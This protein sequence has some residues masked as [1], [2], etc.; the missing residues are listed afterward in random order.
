MED[1]KKLLSYA[2]EKKHFMILSLILSAISTI[3]SFMP[4]YFFFK[5]LR[6]I[7]ST[8]DKNNIKNI[9]ILI[10][11]LT[12]IY[13]FTY[14]LSLICS[15][16][17]AFR[18]ESNMRKEGLRHLLNASF[19]FFD[20]NSSGKTR[21]I[22]DNNASNTH[23]VVAHIL[24]DTVNAIL[25]PICLIVLSFVANFY[26]GLVVVI[27][28]ILSLVCFKFM[29]E[30][31]EAI[32]EYS[33][34]LEQVN[35]E[36]VEYIR[37]IQVIKIFD[38]IVESF[39]RLYNSILNYSRVVNAQCQRC[40]IPYNI[41]QVI[42]FCGIAAIIPVAFREMHL[43]K[44]VSEILSLVV[45]FTTFIG[46]LFVAFMKIMFLSRDFNTAQDAIKRLEDIFVRMEENKLEN[47]N[48]DE[49]KNFDIE[50][51]N[52]TFYY[53]EGNKILENLNLKLEANKKYALIGKSGGGKS[54]IAKIIS[55]F[56][57][58][59][60]GKVKIGGID[61][62]EYSA[63][64]LEK[65]IAFVF[66]N[67]KLFKMSIYENVKIAKPD[68]SYEEVMRALSMAMCDSILDKF[69]ER[70][71]TI[72]GSKGVYLSGGE[73]QRIAVARAI[74][75]DA[76]IVILDEASAA[77]DPENEYEMQR[78]FSELMKNKTVIMIAH[79]LSSIRDVDEALFVENGKIVE[80][81]S[82]NELMKND[83]KYKNFQLLFNEAKEWRL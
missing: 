24:P 29:G 41:F 67:A 72:I 32:K 49:M 27:S 50:F 83:S 66:Q 80:R 62:R 31:P 39:E 15:H 75:K 58:V 48:I 74:L 30:G 22:I 26:V 10:F 64:T 1:L 57:P 8:A 25:F 70:E 44:S 21:K 65:N 46:L 13:T 5:L 36:T 3:L 77:S 47:G 82:H 53:E 55:G 9:S 4:Y 12:F 54:T 81:G 37:G 11:V 76:K 18:L 14:L 42:M 6:E 59:K 56:Y 19:S 52:V 40:R 16:L 79:R 7:S 68:A 61:I 51:E 35:S 73:T 34:A 60:S 23:T 45:F 20:T 38:T 28:I 69:D 71:N 78:A 17:F 43:S 2:K 63:E 33:S